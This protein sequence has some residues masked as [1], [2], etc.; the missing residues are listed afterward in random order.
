MGTV[1][2]GNRTM[3]ISEESVESVV[4]EK[5]LSSNDT[6]CEQA[7]DKNAAESY[8]FH[9][10]GEAVFP[11]YHSKEMLESLQKWNIDVHSHVAKFR[12]DQKFD[13]FHVD[14]FLR[15]FFSD[16]AVQTN[17]QV[18]T[19]H[20][21]GPAPANPDAVRYEALST[22]ATNLDMFD[23]LKTEELSDGNA[24]A[25]E[26]GKIHGCFEEWEDGVCIQDRL[27][28][29]VCKADSEEFE[30]FPA[31]TRQ[32][33][34]FQLFQL[35]V[36]G[37]SMN[38]WEDYVDKYIES[39]K[40]MYKDFV[41]VRKLPDSGRVE[42]ATMAYKVTGVDGG[43]GELFPTPQARNNVCLVLIDPIPR[44]VTFYYHGVVDF[45]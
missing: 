3:K 4:V 10:L 12:F 16:P 41:R 14:Q 38:Q 18:A 43:G 23:V 26:D 13:A 45:I 24:V 1:E 32:E 28:L 20:G 11:N 17:I 42:V 19:R 36:V 35:L 8:S 40:L 2:I 5:G 27:R 39:T 6:Q 37:G 34:L 33:L 30:L 7:E 25:R 29:A 31:H 22:T 21:M 15:D 9:H 44:H